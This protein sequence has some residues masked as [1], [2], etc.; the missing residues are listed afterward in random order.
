MEVTAG[1][2]AC[3]RLLWASHH[4]LRWVINVLVI[5]IYL[6]IAKNLALWLLSK[7]QGLLMSVWGWFSL[8]YNYGLKYTLH[9]YV[10]SLND[11]SN[12][13]IIF[14]GWLFL[15]LKSFVNLY[16]SRSPPP[17]LLLFEHI[18]A[19]AGFG[20]ILWEFDKDRLSPQSL[21]HAN[22]VGWI[23]NEAS[24]CVENGYLT[25]PAHAHWNFR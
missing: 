21:F 24:L 13:F 25:S 15:I 16:F 8:L 11:N 18:C 12:T 4:L 7:G 9:I 14:V 5:S 10:C 19:C 22:W 1:P 3:D 23:R 17:L 2:G 20:N 6:Q